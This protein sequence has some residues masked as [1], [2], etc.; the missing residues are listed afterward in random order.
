LKE[1]TKRFLEQF[2]LS[3]C[4]H[5]EVVA[6]HHI[7]GMFDYLIEIRVPDMESYQHFISNKL[8]SIENIG[9]VQSSF[10]MKELLADR[11][12]GLAL[13]EDRIKKG[14]TA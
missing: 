1:H 11:G 14:K 13:M 10:V 3:I 4:E 6:C 5:P 9:N 8:A 7:A 12:M 2:E